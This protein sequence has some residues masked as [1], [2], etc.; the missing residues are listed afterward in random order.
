MSYKQLI[1]LLLTA[2]LAACSP[3]QTL[4]TTTPTLVVWRLQ[5]TPA[6]KWM[7]PIFNQC[8]SQQ[9]G[10][11]VL[12]KEVSAPFLELQDADLLLRWGENGEIT[13]EAVIIGYD[14]LV[15][16]VH[17]EN[18]LKSL[19]V[20]D[21]TA[22][23]TGQ[24]STWDQLNPAL[25]A[26]SISVWSYADGSETRRVFDELFQAYNPF[27][28]LHLA[29]GPAEMRTALAE[30]PY[31]VGFLPNRWIDESLHSVALTGIDP[32][33]H[34][35]PILAITQSAPQGLLQDWLLCLQSAASI[36]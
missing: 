10:T 23:Y 33:T 8:T 21:L 24:V 29:P 30:D 6:L 25:P 11:G 7:E 27:I 16:A 4:P 22:I 3:T 5:Y 14:T 1:I 32:E 36:Q 20:D 2:A 28:L 9:K 26:E 12:V 34:L 13:G 17:P 19:Q 31:A 35:V 15:V 18:P